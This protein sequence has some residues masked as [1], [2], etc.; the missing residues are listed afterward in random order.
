MNIL[1]IIPTFEEIFDMLK[2]IGFSID[3]L[4]YNGISWMYSVFMS[5][6]S[7]RFFDSKY[8][9]AF[10]DRMYII[11]SIVM[12]FLLAYSFLNVIINPDNMSKGN[13]T[14][15]KLV[16]NVVV[17]IATIVLVP[18]IFDFAFAVQ[19]SVVEENV[20]GKIVLGVDDKIDVDNVDALSGNFSLALFET[21]FYLN[22]NKLKSFDLDGD[23]SSDYLAIKEEFSQREVTSATN[24]NIAPMGEYLSEEYKDVL[25]YNWLFSTL[26]G[27]FVLYTLAT[28][29]IDMGL[30]VIKLLFYQVMAP[31][32]ALMN[33]VPGQDKILKN[34]VKG[35]LKTF[36]DVFIKISVIMLGVFLINLVKDFGSDFVVNFT[37]TN[38]TI[39][40]FTKFLIILGVVMFMRQATKL[41]EDLF[42]IKMEGGMLDI[43]KRF[44]ESGLSAVFG[45]AISSAFGAGASDLGYRARAGRF[46]EQE[47]FKNKFKWLLG[48]DKARTSGLFH[49]A[50][51]GTKAGWYG[52]PMSGIGDAYNYALDTQEAYSRMSGRFQGIRVAGEMLRDNFGIPS[53]Y[54]EQVQLIRTERNAKLKN[55]ENEIRKNEDI[56]KQAEESNE[57]NYQW[58]KRSKYGGMALKSIGS[59]KSHAAEEIRKA[60]CPVSTNAL[61]VTVDSNGKITKQRRVI[62]GEDLDAQKEL[63][64]K[65]IENGDLQAND[66]NELYKSLTDAEDR[67][68]AQFGS[69]AVVSGI[70][71]NEETFK[72]DD[73]KGNLINKI[74]E[75]K[76]GTSY[77][78]SFNKNDQAEQ[79]NTEYAALRKDIESKFTKDPEN[80]KRA[81]ASLDGF[82]RSYVSNQESS[83][84]NWKQISDVADYISGG[85]VVAGESIYNDINSKKRTVNNLNDTELRDY[86][87]YKVKQVRDSVQSGKITEQQAREQFDDYQTCRDV[88]KY[89][90]QWEYE[91]GKLFVDVASDEKSENYKYDSTIFNEVN[92]YRDV[93]KDS[94]ALIGS[95]TKK[96]AKG[97]FILDTSRDGVFDKIS[98]DAG[99]TDLLSILKSKKFIADVS[100]EK[101]MIESS[102][103][104][105]PGVTLS[106][107]RNRNDA[108]REEIKRITDDSEARIKNLTDLSQVKE[109]SEKVKKFR[110][111]HRD[112]K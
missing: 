37:S 76:N 106:T 33:I 93:V 45:G 3:S 32:A 55:L 57:K 85:D 86:R 28:F 20:I 35:V 84:D 16:T 74:G 31:V 9:S 68:V 6:S 103:E 54:D 15:M 94:Q 104:I 11:V 82:V 56:S 69:N 40:N 47:G 61:A 10:V 73:G 14:P 51:L 95:H 83:I 17:A 99:I 18:S 36:L 19:E 46:S 101:T 29:C 89:K 43:R 13:S 22:D 27:I 62:K 41:I 98:S 24:A 59:I 107:N 42:G 21:N 75:V 108:L 112:S 49:G 60:G 5:I 34:W 105:L 78:H 58:S 63:I 2:K 100:A 53:Y 30:R 12:L 96:N 110:G 71:F 81:I 87:A 70:R 97:E 66:A 92:T 25:E 39:I 1:S 72:T 64:Q 8:I 91:A 38:Q 52:K 44:N 23:G 102:K 7:A 50:R 111:K 4:L 80:R 26:A 90:A 109:L 65:G 88:E 79:Y 48:R 77:S 67:L